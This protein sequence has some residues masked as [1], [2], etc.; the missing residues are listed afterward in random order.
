MFLNSISKCF[1]DNSLSQVY[2]IHCRQFSFAVIVESLFGLDIRE[3]WAPKKYLDMLS[4]IYLMEQ[5]EEY[6][7]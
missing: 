6:W 5:F 2:Q 3:N 1:T 7:Y 4:I